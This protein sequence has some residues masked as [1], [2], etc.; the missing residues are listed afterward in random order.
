MTGIGCNGGLISDRVSGGACAS[1][2]T[3]LKGDFGAMQCDLGPLLQLWKFQMGHPLKL[4]VHNGGSERKVR[5]LLLELL[6]VF[7]L[8]TRKYIE[9]NYLEAREANHC[10]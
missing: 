2:E 1:I 9:I 7:G 8:K 10:P 4:S 3:G 5:D 6:L